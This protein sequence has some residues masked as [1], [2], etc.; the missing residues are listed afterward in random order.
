MIKEFLNGADI[1]TSRMSSIFGTGSG[2]GVTAVGFG[3]ELPVLVRP[4]A[5]LND[6]KKRLFLIPKAKIT[7]NLVNSD[8]LMRIHLNV[9]AEYIDT[10]TLKTAMVISCGKPAV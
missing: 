1:A 9:L 4:I 3:T 5:W 6:E 8:K 7:A 2:T 10:A